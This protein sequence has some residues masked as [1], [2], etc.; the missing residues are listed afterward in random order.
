MVIIVIC[1]IAL[2]LGAVFGIFFSGEDSGTGMTMQTVVQEINTD[3]DTK[4]Q[5]EKDAVSYDVL[6]MSGSRAVWKDV[7]AVYAVKTNTDQDNPQ[8]VATMD[9]SNKQIL[10]D[11]FLEMNV[12]SSRT[13]SKIE[14]QITETDDGHV[15]LSLYIVIGKLKS[16]S[17][18]PYSLFFINIFP[19]CANMICLTMSK[20]KPWRCSVVFS[21]HTI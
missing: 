3:Y 19:L 11:I 2:L 15:P 7:L 9:D 10:K 1:L 5:A 8:E 20:P 13:E 21:S 6:E 16:T 12:I 17:K 14:T 4:L 18:P